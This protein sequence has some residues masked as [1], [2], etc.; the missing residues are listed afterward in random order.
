VHFQG[1]REMEK[2]VGAENCNRVCAIK[3][4]WNSS[5]FPSVSQG[6]ERKFPGP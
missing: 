3:G 5:S 6:K 1:A 2:V 4:L